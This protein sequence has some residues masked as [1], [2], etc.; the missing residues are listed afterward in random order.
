MLARFAVLTAAFLVSAIWPP[1]QLLAQNDT[2]VPTSEAAIAAAIPDTDETMR[3]MSDLLASLDAFTLHIEKTFDV[4][5]DDGAKVQ[6]AGAAD[7]AVRRPDRLYVDYGDDV[8][9]KEF[10]YDG[11]SFTLFDPLQGIYGSAPA[12][13]T[14]EGALTQLEEE[15]DLFLPLAGLVRGSAYE[16]YADGVEAKRYLGLHDVEGTPSHHFLFR[17]EHADWQIWIE[18]GERPLPRKIVVT[19]IDLEGAPQQNIVMTGWE[20]DA[21]LEDELFVAE[22]PEGAVR[23]QFKKREEQEP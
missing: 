3:R 16:R 1:G 4:V 19:L 14:I 13:D 21:E 2:A 11:E 22:I 12:A 20:L 15:Y 17:G 6:F 10:W 8:S 7:I 9:A 23:A 5:Q 18:D